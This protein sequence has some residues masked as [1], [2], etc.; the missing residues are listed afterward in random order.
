MADVGAIE[1]GEEEREREREKEIERD[2]RLRGVHLTVTATWAILPY[3][4]L[5]SFLFISF[6]PPRHFSAY[7]LCSCSSTLSRSPS[8]SHLVVAV[9]LSFVARVVR[10]SCIFPV[11]AAAAKDEASTS[12]LLAPALQPPL[13]FP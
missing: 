8:P 11:L 9:A 10:F 5:N 12:Q 6:C 7:Q 2:G 4:K 3:A 1:R 13:H